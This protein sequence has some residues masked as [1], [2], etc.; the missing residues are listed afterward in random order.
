MAICALF[1]PAFTTFIDVH[2]LDYSCKSSVLLGY[3]EHLRG[4]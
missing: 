3:I 2:V 1:Y 4:K